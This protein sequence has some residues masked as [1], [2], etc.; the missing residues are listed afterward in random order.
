MSGPSTT[1]PRMHAAT[2]PCVTIGDWKR[3]AGWQRLVYLE[4]YMETSLQQNLSVLEAIRSRRSIGKCTDEVPDVALIRQMLEAATW[5][6]NHKQT[7]PWRFVVLSGDARMGLG[8]A[9][10]R[11]AVRTSA[12]PEKAMAAFNSAAKKPLRAPYVIAVYAVPNPIVPEV[13]E[14][15]ATAAAVQNMLL[16]AHSIGLAAMWRTGDLVFSQEVREFL[17][18]PEKGIMLGTVY[19]GCPNMEP[20]VRQRRSIEDVTTWVGELPGQSQG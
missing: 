15:A 10:G 1:S 11:A 6:P 14:I 7:E 3:G 19:V 16:A 12:D 18:M 4:R 9:M 20:P 8:E 17:K 5:A 13:E 2:S